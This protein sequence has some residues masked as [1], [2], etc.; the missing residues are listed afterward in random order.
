MK[1]RP[2]L[3]QDKEHI[4]NLLVSTGAFRPE[5]IKVAMEVVNFTLRHRK[6]GDYFIFCALNE[7]DEIIGYICFGSIPLTES[8]FDLYWIAVN[9]HYTR[10]G[11]GRKLLNLAESFC[12]KKGASRIYIDSSS[13]PNYQAARCFYTK[14]LYRPICQLHNFY[15]LGD[16]KII[17]VKEISKK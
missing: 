14:N 1:I 5:E 3:P 15:R 10:R 12:R 13:S 6:K 16:H 11:I 17:F 4:H 7:S 2:L 8:S 9:P